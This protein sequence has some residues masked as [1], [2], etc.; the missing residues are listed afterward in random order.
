MVATGR[1]EGNNPTSYT[2][3]NSTTVPSKQRVGVGGLQTAHRRP[4]AVPVA[5]GVT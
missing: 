3:L 2:M 5:L 4:N 1:L